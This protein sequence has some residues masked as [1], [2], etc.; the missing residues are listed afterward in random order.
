MMTQADATARVAKGAKLL[1]EVRP[2][3]AGRINLDTLQMSSVCNCVLGQQDGT[4]YRGM[5]TLLHYYESRPIKG[6]M[7]LGAEYGFHTGP[8]EMYDLNPDRE[9]EHE[10]V[11]EVYAPLQTAWVREILLRKV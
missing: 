7:E 1:D 10:A 11:V 2:G 9:D 5:Q 4:F 6:A 3:W 8:L